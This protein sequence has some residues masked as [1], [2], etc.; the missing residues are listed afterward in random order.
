M[1]TQS[2]HSISSNRNTTNHE[3]NVITS[4]YNFPLFNIDIRP[5]TVIRLNRI[6]TISPP[7]GAEKSN[8]G[9]IL[10]LQV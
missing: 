8:G 10:C 4:H 9:S 6:I 5:R 1:E 3:H 7:S 2:K